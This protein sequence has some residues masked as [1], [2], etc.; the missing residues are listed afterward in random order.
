MPPE[1][2][3]LTESDSHN[4]SQEPR[5]GPR[6]ADATPS[7]RGGRLA[8]PEAAEPAGQATD[9]PRKIEGRSVAD[10]RTERNVRLHQMPRTGVSRRT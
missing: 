2:E 6:K 7:L 8:G 5:V 9:L 3:G 10:P 4:P 1:L